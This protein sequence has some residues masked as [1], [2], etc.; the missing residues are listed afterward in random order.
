LKDLQRPLVHA[1]EDGYNTRYYDKL[2]HIVP[3]VS[4]F[5]NEVLTDSKNKYLFV[6]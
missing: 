6:V 4:H 1:L 2:I 5:T 3:E